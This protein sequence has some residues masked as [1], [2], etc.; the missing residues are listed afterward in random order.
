MSTSVSVENVTFRYRTGRPLFEGLSLSLEGGE[1][2]IITVMGPSGSGKSTMIRLL[3]G[4][5]KPLH[6]KITMRPADSR[7]TYFPQEAVVF[8][9]L[10]RQVNA[11]YFSLLRSTRRKFEEEVFRLN[12]ERLRMSAVIATPAPTAEMSGGERQRLA[13]LRA[14]SIRPGLLLLDEPCNALDPSVKHEFMALL[15]ELTDEYQLLV[16]Y[17][18]HHFDEAEVVADEMIYLSASQPTRVSHQTIRHFVAAPPA[19]EAAA[20]LFGPYLN[21]LRCRV[22]GG[23]VTLESEEV[24]ASVSNLSEGP[25][26]ATFIPSAIRFSARGAAVHVCGTSARFLFLRLNDARVRVTL[27]ASDAAAGTNI[28]LE[29]EAHF[30]NEDGTFAKQV[31]LNPL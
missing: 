9:H 31:V 28:S 24:V 26:I 11:R 23:Q 21:Q 3:A 14:L 6:G 22:A 1:G 27:A 5:E 20:T 29:G 2:K 15:R 7:P 30:F 17:V 25:Y 19:V 12:A 4:I 18:T 8:E 16:V 13:L 10:S